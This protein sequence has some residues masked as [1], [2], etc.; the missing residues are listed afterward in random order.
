MPL[1]GA[2][3]SFAVCPDPFP[4]LVAGFGS[5]KTAAGIARAM[6]LKAHW[7]E[8]NVGYYLPTYP[9][10]EDIAYERFPELCERKGWAYKLHKGSAPHISFP[11]AGKIIF[12]TLEKPERIVG[13]EVGDSIVD[14]LDTLP[15]DKARHAWT[16]IIARNRQKKRRKLPDGQV[17]IGKNS[18][19]VITTPEG[20]R[21]VHERWVK[22]KK[23]GDGYTLFHMSTYDNAENLPEDYI[24]NLRNTYPAALLDAYLMGQFVNL[25][26]G[27]V[28]PKFHRKKNYTA[29]KVRPGD[30]LHIGMDFNVMHMAAIVHVIDE[31]KPRAVK[32][33]VEVFDTPAMI[34]LLQDTYWKTDSG[35]LDPS[36]HAIF[37]YPDASG[38]QR[39]SANASETDLTL[40][41]A[42]GFIVVVDHQNPRVRDRVLSMNKVIEDRD[43]LVNTDLCPVYTDCLEKQAYDKNGEPDKSAGFDHPVDAGGYFIQKRYPVLKPVSSHES[44]RI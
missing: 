26:S 24:D 19:G 12:R 4:A 35:V 5:G 38:K 8:Q 20:F 23:A 15:I 22:K 16:K 41:K 2:Q 17:Q 21:F 31:Q 10:V 28:Y 32:E 44:L 40:L 9:L 37:I 18:V 11:N 30:A 1:I 42:A 34:R 13:Y 29:R 27:S 14:E 7:R 33:F 43:Y 25:T 6:A 3:K 39:H 36:R